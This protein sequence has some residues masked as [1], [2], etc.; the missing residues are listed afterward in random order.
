MKK[1]T[2]K[3]SIY[4]ANIH[5]HTVLARTYDDTQPHFRIENAVQ[6]KKRIEGFARATDAQRLLDLGCGTGFA[7]SLSHRY[8]EESYGIDI[9]PGMLCRASRMTRGYRK[10]NIKLIRGFSDRLPFKDS[11]FDVIVAYGFLHHLPLLLPT[12]KEVR[13]VLKKGGLFYSDQDPNYYF[14]R[15]MRS[16]SRDKNISN[17]LEIER[18][19]ISRVVQKIRKIYKNKLDKK[20]IQMAEYLKSKGGFKENT[21]RGLFSRSGF[22]K[23]KYEY[24]WFWQEGEV[25]KNL[26]LKNALYLEDHLRLALPLSRSFFKYIRIIAIK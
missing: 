22:K 3:K 24:T 14:W 26:S 10:S 23:I 13:R 2:N 20:T 9:T 7:L 16:I 12:L 15:D 6:V 17:L 19:S 8:F 1:T 25:I 21:V 11:S 4:N 18:D 5:Y